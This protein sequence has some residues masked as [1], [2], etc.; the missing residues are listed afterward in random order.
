PSP[1][2]VIISSSGFKMNDEKMR[3][4]GIKA[5]LNKPYRQTDLLEAVYQSLN[6]SQKES[7]ENFEESDIHITATAESLNL[8][9]IIDKSKRILIAEDN[10]VNQMVAKNMLKKFGYTADVAANGRE[11]LQALEILPYDLV[12]MDCQMPEMDGYEATREIRARD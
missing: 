10:S 3:E 7:F 9:Q 5:F 8:P 6:I 2:I 11:A 4:F 12:L 1:A